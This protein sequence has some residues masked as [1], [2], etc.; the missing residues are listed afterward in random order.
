MLQTM[1][2][3]EFRANPRP[4]QSTETVKPTTPLHIHI[5]VQHL[6][7]GGHL[8]RMKTLAAALVRAG[9]RVTLISGGTPGAH[10]ERAYRLVQLPPVKVAAGDFTTLL[11]Q[12]GAPV[13]DD[14]KARRAAQLRQVV[15]DEKPQALLLETFPFGRRALRFELVPLLQMTAEFRPRPLTLCSL[16]DILQLRTAARYRQSVDEVAAWFDHILVHADPAVATLAETFPLA[17]ELGDKVF[18]TGYV[19]QPPPRNDGGDAGRDEVIVSA[20]GGAVGMQL[21]RTAL[22]AR[23]HSRLKARRWRLLVGGNVAADEFNALQQSAG[24]QSGG[25]GVVVERN[26][27]DFAALL[28]RCAVSV[29]QAGYNTVL[30][31]VAANCRA[32]LVPYSQDGETEQAARAQK[33]AALGR[34]VVAADAADAAQLAA[35]IDRAASLDLSRCRP[36]DLNG[37]ARSVDFIEQQIAARQ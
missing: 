12:D 6:L 26:R 10:E 1:T 29:S 20:G 7:G 35:A 25:G 21:L 34:A 23:H 4:T 22:V 3:L 11:G 5:Y 19:Y 33:M 31:A 37:A 36:L 15:A 24:A 16:R 30:D 9:H 27:A 32:A 18:H 13:D 17:S 28:A 2:A 14:F 8:V